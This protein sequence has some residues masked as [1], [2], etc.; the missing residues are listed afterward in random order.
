MLSESVSRAWGYDQ[1]NLER[2]RY[3]IPVYTLPAGN[4]LVHSLASD[5][6]ARYFASLLGGFDSIS[7]PDVPPGVT[8]FDQAFRAARTAGNDYFVLLAVD[9]ADRSFSVHRGPVSRPN[10][11]PDR[12]LRGVPHR[13]TTGS[14]IP[15]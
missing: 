12:E 4:R 1:Y 15:S 13:A 10:R 6:L 2:S 8:G 7:T 11:G 5:D 14:G 9:E 3:I